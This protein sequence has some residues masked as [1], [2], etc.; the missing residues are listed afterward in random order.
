MGVPMF[1]GNS[2]YT[3]TESG[4]RVPTPLLFLE[5]KKGD[6]NERRCKPFI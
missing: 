5:L 2:R 3:A 1:S 6:N 4:D